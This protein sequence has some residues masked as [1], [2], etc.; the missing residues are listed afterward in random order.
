MTRNNY[1][2]NLTIFVK[3]V[4]HEEIIKEYEQFGW[5]LVSKEE[6]QRYED[7][8]DLSFTRHHFIENK[9]ELQLYQVY[10]EDKMNELGKLEKYKHSNLI[11]LTLNFGIFGLAFIIFGLLCCFNIL[12]HVGIIVGSIAIFLGLLLFVFLLITMPKVHK[13]EK[14]Y[15]IKNKKR[16]EKEIKEISNKAGVLT[17]GKHGKN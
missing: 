9:D 12:P 17:G 6:N 1:N 4:K 15:F 10:M 14:E 8:L 16:L 2:D 7:I 13:E 11:S 5:E 3:K